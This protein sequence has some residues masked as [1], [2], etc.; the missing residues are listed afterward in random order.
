MPL[1][2]LADERQRAEVARA[3]HAERLARAERRQAV[4][5][6]VSCLLFLGCE[7]FLAGLSMHVT[8]QRAVAWALSGAALCGI[9]PA[10]MIVGWQLR[11]ERDE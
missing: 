5:V 7:V 2:T 6:F 1:L 8:T 10:V 9:A 3:E 11:R 4:W